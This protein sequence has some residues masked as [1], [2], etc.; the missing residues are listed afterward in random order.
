MFYVYIVIVWISIQVYNAYQNLLKGLASMLQVFY[1][2]PNRLEIKDL[3]QGSI[4]AGDEVVTKE[5]EV[6]E[7]SFY[8]FYLNQKQ[9]LNSLAIFILF[10]EHL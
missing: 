6:M 2:M 3:M 4:E 5:E 10:P 9:K 1:G 7:Y 8:I